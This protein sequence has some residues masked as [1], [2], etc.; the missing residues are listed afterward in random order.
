MKAKG[1]YRNVV[2][3]WL[4]VSCIQVSYAQE[5]TDV[6]RQE[7]AQEAETSFLQEKERKEISR[8]WQQYL[9]QLSEQE[10]YEQVNW[11]DYATLLEDYAEH[12]INL[13]TASRED[14]NQ[15]PFL[16]ARQIEDIQAYIYQYGAMKSM[17]ELAMIE[18][19]DWYQRQLLGCFV[20]VGEV[21]KQTFPTL[22]QIA[23]YGKHELVGAVKVP[24]YERKGDKEGYMGYPYRHWLRYQFK[25]GDY[26][27]AGVVASQDAGEPFFGGKN[28]L[29]YDFYSY[30]LQI[31]KWGRL[32]N[33]TIGK[34]RLRTG[35]GLMLNNDFGFGKLSMLSSFGRMGTSIRV[36]SSR[37]AANYLQG[38]AATVN[39]TKGLDCSAFLSYRK[40]DATVKNDSISTIIET[41]L[42][43][44]EKEIEKQKA[45]SA[46][47][48]G[49]NVHFASN[50]WHLGA[51]G[52]CYGY[53]MPLHPNKSQLCK[54]YAPEGKDF[55]NASIDY[56]Y[57]SHRLT[58]QG[59]AAMGDCGVVATINSAS[60]LF[61]E[62]FSL[63]ALYRFYPYR[64]YALYSNSFCAGS[65]VQDES[66]CY[67][68]MRWSPSSKWVIEAYGDIAYFAWPKYR[69]TESTYAMDWLASVVWQPSSSVSL[70]ARY[71][72]KNK[73]QVATQ[74]A[75]FSLGIVKKAWSSKTQVDATSLE[76][77]RGYML[78]ENLSW[79]FGWLRLNSV[80]GYFYTT[81]YDSRVYAYEPNL[82]YTM[83]FGSYFG[84]GIRYALLARAEMGKHLLVV[85][86]CSTTDY[87]DRNHISSGYQQIDGSSQT[88]LEVQVKWK[89]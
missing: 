22:G 84:H 37:Y 33:L 83:S 61:S 51:T 35:M 72:Y 18:S 5:K 6:F 71:Q 47:L 19:I 66:G 82:L 75:R 44:T 57:I 1:F 55:W 26:V 24:F 21:K 69:M 60:Y 31:R 16:S 53:S 58:L 39:I 43:R 85:C 81:D 38:G 14:L 68:G 56:G 54:R 15:F 45:A 41:G 89:F 88:D 36:H 79:K 63:L 76:A 59:E 34:Y 23:K 11:E 64:Y 70:G 29:G 13:N 86:K 40:I 62:H 52:I 28:N 30:Y 25:Y 80:F 49:A 4:M 10:E 17:G 7:N 50:G 48:V 9:E 20:Y 65:D 78:S 32:K 3:V 73:Y 42:H 8:P 67:V 27:K 46:F 77:S 87:F 12:P 2:G 74:R